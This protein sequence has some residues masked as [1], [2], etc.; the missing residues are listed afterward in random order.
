MNVR[1]VHG[2]GY[3][4]DYIYYILTSRISVDVFVTGLCD[5]PQVLAETVREA[6]EKDLTFKPQIT[7]KKTRAI[8][9]HYG[10]FLDE[11]QAEYIAHVVY[12]GDYVGGVCA[13]L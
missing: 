12:V 2:V 9:S 6:E 10:N 3:S 4:V 11:M 1:H 13:C 8:T 5:G 7:S